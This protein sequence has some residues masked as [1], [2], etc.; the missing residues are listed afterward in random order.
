MEGPHGPDGITWWDRFSPRAGF[1]P[2]LTYIHLPHARTF[3]YCLIVSA[4]VQ[5]LGS[6]GG[7]SLGG[8]VVS[9]REHYSM[10]VPF[11]S[12]PGRLM[13]GAERVYGPY[14]QESLCF[15]KQQLS[16]CKIQKVSWRPGL[17]PTTA[18]SHRRPLLTSTK[19]GSCLSNVP[20]SVG[21]C[22]YLTYSIVQW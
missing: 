21:R 12:E 19:H 20:A 10:G 1:Y 11:I 7:G 4:T 3:L 18:F 15:L 17:E 14:Y 22:P 6:L 16:K 2:S 8:W 9:A 5:Q 13:P